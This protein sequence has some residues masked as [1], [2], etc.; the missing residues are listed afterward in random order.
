MKEKQTKYK[1]ALETIYKNIEET[2]NN[3]NNSLTFKLKFPS[4]IK[5]DL[6]SKN[7]SLEEREVRLPSDKEG[8]ELESVWFTIISWEI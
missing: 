8:S 3:G 6:K 2:K 5:K 7:Y 4:A 1:E